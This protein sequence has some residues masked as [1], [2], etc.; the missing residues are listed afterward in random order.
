MSKIQYPPLS[1]AHF[2][3]AISHYLQISEEIFQEW[4]KFKLKFKPRNASCLASCVNLLDLNCHKFSVYRLSDLLLKL[5]GERFLALATRKRH[6]LKIC[7]YDCLNYFFAN[8]AFFFSRVAEEKQV[9]VEP[10]CS[11]LHLRE[12]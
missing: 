9:F 11:E 5:V 8:Y 1:V 12:F 4:L 2:L 6:S 10:N 3:V 7:L